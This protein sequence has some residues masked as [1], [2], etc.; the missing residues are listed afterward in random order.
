M[1]LTVKKTGGDFE[2]APEGNHVAV[3]YM[4]IDLGEQQTVWNG[5]VKHSHKIRFGWE[6][7]NEPM[8]DGRPFGVFKD[9]T[10]SLNDKA[11]LR[12]DLQSWRGR[13]FTEEELDGFD[14]FNVLGAPCMINVVHSVSEKNGNTYANVASIAPLPKGTNKPDLSNSLVKFSLDDFDQKVFDSLPEWLQEKINTKGVDKPYQPPQS[15]NPAPQG[16][17]D[18]EDIPF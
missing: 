18:L 5:D 4:V 1:A 2:L 14:V 6:L 16:F 8:S 17:D 15:E 3:C 13:A 10:A 7:S 11:N 12:K 9:Y